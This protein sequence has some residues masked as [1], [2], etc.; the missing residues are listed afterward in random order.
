ML[1]ELRKHQWQN[2]KRVGQTSCQF[3]V[4]RLSYFVNKSVK[5]IHIKL[6]P[7]GYGMAHMAAQCVDTWLGCLLIAAF[8]NCL[9]TAVHVGQLLLLAVFLL[10]IAFYHEEE[11]TFYWV[12]NLNLI[13][14]Y[15]E[16][17]Y[18]NDSNCN[19]E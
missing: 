6:W 17:C 2:M 12:G 1:C 5:L 9:L 19:K 15:S 11:W 4:M 3:Q 16:I 10:G 7:F 18:Q 8:N 13:L 14:D